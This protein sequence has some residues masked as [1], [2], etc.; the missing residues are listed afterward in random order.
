MPAA[1]L[2]VAL[3]LVEPGADKLARARALAVAR[4]PLPV[5]MRAIHPTWIE[6]ALEG[7]PERSRAVVAGVATR[8]SAAGARAGVLDSPVDVWLARRATAHLPSMIVE[9]ALAKLVAAHPAWLLVDGI[10]TAPA[11]A[12]V[13][14][15][16]SIG[17]DQ[18]AFATGSAAPAGALAR[19]GDA[20]A[21]I[22]R[23]PRKGQLG[24]RRE[25]IARCQG[26]AMDELAHVRIGARAL[27]ARVRAEA[28]AR[29]AAQFARQLAVRFPRPIGQVVHRELLAATAGAE[30]PAW[31]ALLA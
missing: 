21:R 22:E 26:V 7:Q 27:G 19:L 20:P 16:D 25:A 13:A 14:W 24:S 18:L 12:L 2:L 29:S 28:A 8:T 23:A 1:D 5:G 17:A 30:P 15:L 31:R 3:G 11:A 6:A 9:P 10:P 4:A